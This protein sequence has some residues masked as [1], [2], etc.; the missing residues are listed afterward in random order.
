MSKNLDAWWA[1]S[2]F[3]K[4]VNPSLMHHVGVISY[5][6]K[7]VR[8]GL[9]FTVE[10]I[11]L[12]IWRN[13]CVTPKISMVGLDPPPFPER[14]LETML[15]NA[16]SIYQVCTLYDLRMERRLQ[17]RLRQILMKAIA[18]LPGLIHWH[19]NSR[20]SNGWPLGGFLWQRSTW[21][22]HIFNCPLSV[23]TTEKTT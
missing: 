7:V 20:G 21:D 19:R 18:L 11:G 14:D 3:S 13:F 15:P 5:L 4:A 17:G 2:N 10:R 22:S 6:K 9:G 12:C 23:V 8:W 1:M 16:T